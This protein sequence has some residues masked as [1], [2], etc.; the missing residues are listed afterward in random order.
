LNDL[1][2]FHFSQ[3]AELSATAAHNIGEEV[4][5]P[6]RVDGWIA[7]AKELTAE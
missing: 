4:G 6:G 7:K 3:I 2:I 1:G 5:L